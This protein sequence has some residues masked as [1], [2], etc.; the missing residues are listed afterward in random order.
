M[1][2]K[3]TARYYYNFLGLNRGLILSLALPICLSAIIFFWDITIKSSYGSNLI[4]AAGYGIFVFLHL[5]WDFRIR[6]KHMPLDIENDCMIFYPNQGDPLKIKIED[7]ESIEKFPTPENIYDDDY[8]SSI[9]SSGIKIYSSGNKIIIFSKIK[10][11]KEIKNK[12][13]VG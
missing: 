13:G 2:N 7:I 3:N 4:L 8:L 5:L 1:M 9:M 12:L 10:G 6:R 11:F